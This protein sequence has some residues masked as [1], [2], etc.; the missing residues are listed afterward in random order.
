MPKFRA[1]IPFTHN[2]STFNPADIHLHDID[3]DEMVNIWAEAGYCEIVGP[4]DQKEEIEPETSEAINEAVEAPEV[5]EV[6]KP[7]E[8]EETP[9]NDKKTDNSVDYDA[10]NYPQLKK[11]A[12]EA[13]IKG[14]NTMKQVDLIKV[15]KG[16]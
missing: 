6:E 10:M 3:N 5:V 7:E 14:Y 13:G 16:E 9:K 12:K 4:S 2:L 15:L 1:L 8:V 11:A